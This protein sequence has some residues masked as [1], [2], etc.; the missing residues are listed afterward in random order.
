MAL[1]G[2]VTKLENVLDLE[3]LAAEGRCTRCGGQFLWDWVKKG[4]I[5]PAEVCGTLLAALNAGEKVCSCGLD[6]TGI[7]S[8]DEVDAKLAE[9]GY[10]REGQ[11]TSP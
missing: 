3:T 5:L 1:A 8:P 9:L 7:L 6:L 10:S 2:R 11:A 4:P